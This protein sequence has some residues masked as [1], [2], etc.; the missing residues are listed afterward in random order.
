MTNSQKQTGISTTEA[1][2]RRIHGTALKAGGERG[3]RIANR[4]TGALGLGTIDLSTGD[5][6]ASKAR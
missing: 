3:S 6:D 2:C 1:V 5:L 4:V